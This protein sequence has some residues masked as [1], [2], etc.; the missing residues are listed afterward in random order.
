M[1]TFAELLTKHIE[2]AGTTDTRLA[3]AIGV[4]RQTIFRWKEGLTERPRNCDDVLACAKQ[5]RLN[6]DETNAL[7]L[8]AGCQ[9]L[10]LP[11][12]PIK[13]IIP[14]PKLE[15]VEPPEQHT[16]SPQED[17]QVK[18]SR[19]STVVENTE[20][21]A[22]NAVAPAP[23]VASYDNSTQIFSTHNRPIWWFFLT[24]PGVVLLPLCL[25]AVGT[26]IMLSFP[27][28]PLPPIVT[29]LPPP[30]S[31]IYPT[32]SPSLTF[33]P[34]TAANSTST[35]TPIVILAE[36]DETL[37]LVS[38]FK[39]IGPHNF[40]INSR[41]R[42]ALA[43]EIKTTQLLNTSVKL[44]SGIVEDEEQAQKILET[45]QATMLIH[46]EYDH[47]RVL[48]NLSLRGED[49]NADSWERLLNSP[50]E[51]PTVINYDVADETRILALS[52][53]VPVY[54]DS[55]NRILALVSLGRLYRNN[56]DYDNAKRFF[57]QALDLT[58]TEEDT[59]ASLRFY[60]GYVSERGSASDIPLAIQYYS[61][62]LRLKPS[63]INAR[64]NRGT[65]YRN[66]AYG[67]NDLEIAEEYLDKAIQDLSKVLAA[68]KT[69]PAY[70]NRGIAYYERQKSGDLAKAIADFDAAQH[71]SGDDYRIYFNRG[72]TRIRA[73]DSIWITDILQALELKSEYAPIYNA[74]CWGYALDQAPQEALLH[75]KQAIDLG[76]T[77]NS[78]DG[79]GLAYAQLGQLA[80]AKTEFEAYLEWLNMKYPKLYERYQGP[81]IETWITALEAGENP[82]TP[83]ILEELR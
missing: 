57:E 50:D 5:L 70:L 83:D 78:R 3:K 20:N 69:I 44:W 80:E 15:P 60:L 42:T 39:F 75:C 27:A 56:G 45:T 18:E 21:H 76:D 41:V 63:W 31:T 77:G 33:T 6:A 72:L 10:N 1:P 79:L 62:V 82:I 48:V 47:G 36:E 52:R 71:L 34:T 51:L 19:E 17:D 40:F 73:N 54:Q 29:S 37:I 59:E 16:K 26:L 46:G 22:E 2:S 68:K 53:L 8:A 13:P 58:P 7:L 66:R 43:N 9:P 12:P 24:W 81:L 35:A 74:L 65:A 55:E 61:D 67:T 14:V 11:K 32:P 4:T 28:S 38:D 23:M 64:Y 49:A 30:T 25:L